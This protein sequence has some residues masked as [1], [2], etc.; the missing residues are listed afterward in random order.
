ML[1][2]RKPTPPRD[3]VGCGSHAAFTPLRPD[4]SPAEPLFSPDRCVMPRP[5][6]GTLAPRGKD[7]LGP[8]GKPVGVWLSLCEPC[9]PVSQRR[10]IH[11]PP[12]LG[13]QQGKLYWWIMASQN[14]LWSS[15]RTHWKVWCVSPGARAAAQ[16][17]CET[18]RFH[19]FWWSLRMS[20]RLTRW[21]PI[22]RWQGSETRG[23]IQSECG[24]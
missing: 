10:V 5:G 13:S 11:H 4:L 15:L 14:L 2:T 17:S 6:A 7:L 12:S 24:V 8:P 1:G 9:G 23:N 3:P 22:C 16:F 20:H 18:S 21:W 19:G